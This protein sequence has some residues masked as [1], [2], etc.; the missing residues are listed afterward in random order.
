MNYK[1]YFFKEISQTNIFILITKTSKKKIEEI[2]NARNYEIYT[3]FINAF[4]QSNFFNFDDKD[5]SKK[6]NI[7]DCS[8]NSTNSQLTNDDSFEREISD[9]EIIIKKDF[10]KRKRIRNNKN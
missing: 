1:F 4:S 3:D 6:N 5:V 7:Q 8:K 9:E 2:Q 10:V